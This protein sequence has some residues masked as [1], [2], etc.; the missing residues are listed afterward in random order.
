MMMMT[1][2]SMAASVTRFSTISD[3][4]FPDAAAN[5]WRHRSVSDHSRL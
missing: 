1:M 3:Q 2:M 4:A 5:T